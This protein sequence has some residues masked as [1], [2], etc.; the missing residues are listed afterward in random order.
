MHFVN[1]PQPAPDVLTLRTYAVHN[2]NSPRQI[3]S[4]LTL[5]TPAALPSRG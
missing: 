2:V 3:P 5:C 1:T 4:L